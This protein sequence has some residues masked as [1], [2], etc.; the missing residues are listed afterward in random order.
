MISLETG[1]ENS[2]LW[3]DANSVCE[4]IVNRWLIRKQVKLFENLNLLVDNQFSFLTRKNCIYWIFRF[5]NSAQVSAASQSV[6]LLN[7]V[8]LLSLVQF[9]VS[10]ACSQYSSQLVQLSSWCSSLV[11]CRYQSV[12][13]VQLSVSAY[14]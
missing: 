2:I 11:G 7:S 3:E 10:A 6:Q 8:Q 1:T 4:E 12:Q 5:Q 9:S 13:L 14:L